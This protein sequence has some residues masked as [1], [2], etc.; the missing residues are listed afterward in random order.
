VNAANENSPKQPEKRPEIAKIF[1]THLRQAADVLV[2]DL[3]GPGAADTLFSSQRISGCADLVKS[4]QNHEGFGYD[5]YGGLHFFYFFAPGFMGL[6]LHTSK[7]RLQDSISTSHLV[8]RVKML[9][10][11][12]F[13]I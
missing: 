11:R 5:G 13:Y 3:P 7:F 9:G 4:G 12:L 8:Y 6:F 2:T 10:F 1:V